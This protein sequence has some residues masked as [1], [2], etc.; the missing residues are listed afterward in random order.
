M[1][2][3]PYARILCLEI[4]WIVQVAGYH[5]L[6][7]VA[8]CTESQFT[9]KLFPH[10]H[11]YVSLLGYLVPHH[12]L[13]IQLTNLLHVHLRLCSRVL[14]CGKRKEEVWA[15]VN[16]S[17]KIYLQ[18]YSS[19]LRYPQLYSVL[20]YT[21]YSVCISERCSSIVSAHCSP[22]LVVSNGTCFMQLWGGGGNKNMPQKTAPI[23]RKVR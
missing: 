6:W 11:I 20:S 18:I 5:E 21:S 16:T 4:V 8:S 14:L 9:Y 7:K 23:S 2:V 19:F 10:A 22:I 17:G 3:W 15:W 12:H 13:L 1:E